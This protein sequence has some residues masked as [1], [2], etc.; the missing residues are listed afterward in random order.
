VQSPAEPTRLD[1]LE[2]SEPGDA[3]ERDAERTA[4]AA[5]P[6]AR[7]PAIRRQT[8]NAEPTGT[9]KA[10]SE[11]ELRAMAARPSLALPRWSS[12][13]D[14]SRAFVIMVMTD[15]YGPDFTLDF[16]DYATG[17]KK[18]DI[19]GTVT[20]TDTPQSLKQRGYK[21]CCNPGGIPVYVHPSGHELQL[22]P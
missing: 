8:E 20:N 13:D 4:D 5:L 3:D 6:P 2:V 12:L 17:K 18:P 22:L 1:G 16:L 14:G 11:E 9:K 15:R 21:L 10:P 19:S 7:G